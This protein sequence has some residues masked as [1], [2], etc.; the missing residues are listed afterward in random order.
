M[1]HRKTWRPIIFSWSNTGDR[2]QGLLPNDAV[3]PSAND[4]HPVTCVACDGVHVID[5]R[6]GPTRGAER[7]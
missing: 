2:V 4:L 1:T 7:S 5:P 6:T 3:E